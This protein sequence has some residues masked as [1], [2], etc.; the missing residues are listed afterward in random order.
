MIKWRIYYANGDTFDNSRGEKKDAPPFGVV[1]IVYPD[2]LVGRV[3][4]HGF[5][6]YYWVP[7]HEQWWGSDIYG[8]LDRLLHNLPLY[9][10]K[11]GRSVSNQEYSSIMTTAD[12]DPDFPPKSGKRAGEQP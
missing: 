5:D 12:K 4:M 2:D 9:A 6:W 1:C 11:Q 3:I 7:G 10:L 8:V